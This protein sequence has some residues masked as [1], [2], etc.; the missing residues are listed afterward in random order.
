MPA[1]VAEGDLL[2]AG[3]DQPFGDRDHP[4]LRNLA[5]VWAPERHGDHALAAQPLAARPFHHRLQPYQRLL[6]G[7]VHVLAVVGLRCG[8][9]HIDLLEAIP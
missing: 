4:L 8:E 2:A 6:H 9:E 7:P 1:G 3:G 5:F